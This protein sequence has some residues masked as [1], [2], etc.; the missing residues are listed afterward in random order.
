MPSFFI[1]SKKRR[2]RVKG[3]NYIIAIMRFY[4]ACTKFNERCIVFENVE[5][6]V[7]CIRKKF[8]CDLTSFNILR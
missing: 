2:A 6:C 3:L 5:K 8:F 1:S 4:K 7:K